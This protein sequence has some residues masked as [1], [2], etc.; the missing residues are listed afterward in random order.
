[1][2]DHQLRI[3]DLDQILDENI[4]VSM[5]FAIDF[6]N[7]TFRITGAQF[8]NWLADNIEFDAINVSF[9]PSTLDSLFPSAPTIEN[10]QD[11]IDFSLPISANADAGNIGKI[12]L[13]ATGDNLNLKTTTGFF[14]VLASSSN[15]PVNEI[16]SLIVSSL[17]ATNTVQMF[18]GL[19]SGSLHVR[20]QSGGTWLSWQQIATTANLDAY[21]PLAGGTVTGV[22]NFEPTP[23]TSQSVPTLNNELA[24]K[25]YVDKRLL[26]TG[27]TV[28]GQIKGITPSADADLTRKDY[29]DGVLPTTGANFI[30]IG[31]RLIQWGSQQ[32][33]SSTPETITLPTPFDNAGYS[34]TS[35]VQGVGSSSVSGYGDAMFTSKTTTQFVLSYYADNKT[36]VIDWQA[37]GNAP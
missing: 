16:G 3:I 5:N 24:R 37:I 17:D 19:A 29:V 6:T 30:K 34:L 21:L 26:K 28:T 35:G 32:V 15:T 31:N 27:G 12:D 14:R 33:A 20:R 23:R 8:S 18:I 2:S 4:S 9:D 36:H 22:V 1:M 11:A 10:A 25:D 13:I 7:Q